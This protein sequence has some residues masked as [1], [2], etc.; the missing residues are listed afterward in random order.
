MKN[1][2]RL[3]LALIAVAFVFG[4]SV[5]T[6]A[7]DP[8]FVRALYQKMENNAK[9]LTTLKTGIRMEKYNSQLRDVEDKRE[10]VGM[11]VPQ[12]NR[13]A[14]F[15]IDWTKGTTE[16]LS[17]VNGKYRLYQPNLNQVVEGQNKDVQ[18]GNPENVFSIINM[19]AKD[20]KQ[21]FDAQWLGQEVV[22][23]AFSTYKM[24]LTPKTAQKFD[25]S[26]IWVNENGMVVQLKI[27]EKNGDWTNILLFDSQKNQKISKDALGLGKLP[28]DVKVIKG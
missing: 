24:K 3:L 13:T 21:N 5:P 9:T 22:A 2:F 12:K 16:T 25:Y 27:Y 28:K 15:K 18:K 6:R 7:Q 8:Q 20:L 17:V 23:N 26:E 19:S 1:Y 10:G 4:L 14:N 11:F